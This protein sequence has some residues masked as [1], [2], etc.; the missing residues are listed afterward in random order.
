MKIKSK[1]GLVRLFGIKVLMPTE[2]DVIKEV[3]TGDK[4]ESIY[5]GKGHEFAVYL[6]YK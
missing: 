1:H 2:E 4:L 5:Y 6:K 3:L